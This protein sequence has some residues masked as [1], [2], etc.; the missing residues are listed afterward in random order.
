MITPNEQYTRLAKVIGYDDLYFKREDLHP[1]G[2]HKGRSIPVMI[3]YHYAKGSKSFAVS[4]SG[5]AALAAALYIKDMPDV[6]LEI[7]VGE[8]ISP[9]KLAKLT[10]IAEEEKRIKV[11]GVARPVQAL[12]Q[13][14]QKGATSLR[15]STDDTALIGYE[16]LAKE[17]STMTKVSA[18][19]MGTSSGTTAQ[20]LAQYFLKGKRSVQVHIV[21]TSSCHPM[22]EEFK[23][24]GIDN[25]SSLADAIVDKTAFR[26]P[27]LLPLIKQTGGSG[28][29]ATNEDILMAQ[30]LTKTY[31]GLDI[32]TNSA[33]SVVGTL[34][35]ARA[36]YAIKGPVVCVIC[37]D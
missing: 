16:S 27:A 15:Q 33:L 3:D 6:S 5:N 35:A 13:A 22:A 17:I 8:N 26:K 31:T 28:W 29:C 23:N 24:V 25:E 30:R 34:Q 37:G 11:T 1:L 10:K 36:K 32:S 18:V 14:L 7:F 21:Q 9:T 2:S 20:A 19:F 12:M 4:S